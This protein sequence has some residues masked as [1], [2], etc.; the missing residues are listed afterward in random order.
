[1]ADSSLRLLV[2]ED[3]GDLRRALVAMVKQLGVRM[4]QTV[5]SSGEAQEFIQ[6]NPV[7]FIICEWQLPCVSPCAMIEQN[8]G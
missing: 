7:D 8:E 1:M 5:G 3:Q 2:V 4:V 6:E